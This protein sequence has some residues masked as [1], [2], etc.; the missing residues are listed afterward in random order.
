M[1]V[2]KSDAFISDVEGQYEWYAIHAD[3]DIAERHLQA[4]EA[5][6]GL[7][8]HHP[9]IGPRTGFSHPHLV[10]WRFMVVFRPFQKHVIF[11]ESKGGEVFLRRTMHGHRNLPE[12]L[13]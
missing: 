13:I 5:T 7:L 6:C 10:H 12:R 4:I 9:L 8:D 3:G 2:H 1:S 11:Y